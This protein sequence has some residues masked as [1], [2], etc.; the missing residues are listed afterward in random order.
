VAAEMKK[1]S[2]RMAAE[3]AARKKAAEDAEKAERAAR[4]AALNAQWSSSKS[5]DTTPVSTPRKA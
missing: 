4:K 5:V 2:E 3:E 1:Q